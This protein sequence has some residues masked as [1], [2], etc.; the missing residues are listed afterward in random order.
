MGEDFL[1]RCP[2]ELDL[3]T[4]LG[5]RALGQQ[6]ALMDDQHTIRNGLDVGDD[7]G[8]EQDRSSWF[9]L[10]QGVAEGDY[11]HRIEAVGRF[12]E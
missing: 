11:L 8:A 1:Q 5:N 4:K 12:V 10:A 9:E 7:V 2:R 3:V 6:L